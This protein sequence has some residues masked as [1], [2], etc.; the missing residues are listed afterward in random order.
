VDTCLRYQNQSQ[1]SPGGDGLRGTAHLRQSAVVLMSGSNT[2][3]VIIPAAYN[4]GGFVK[5]PATNCPAGSPVIPSIVAFDLED[6]VGNAMPAKSTVAA[7]V[8]T[9]IVGAAIDPA[10]VPNLVLGLSPARDSLNAPKTSTGLSDPTLIGTIHSLTLTPVASTTAVG[11]CVTGS[12]NV[13]IK[14]TTPSGLA[15]FARI[16]FEGE[17]RSTS[18]FAVPVQVQ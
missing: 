16:L 12:G 11:S 8:Q 14:V 4:A 5:V 15:T 6:G 17:P 1:C 9:S 10:A 7:V 18:R 3:T 13:Q 2:P